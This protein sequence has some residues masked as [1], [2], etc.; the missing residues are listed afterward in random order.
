MSAISKQDVQSRYTNLSQWLMWMPAIVRMLDRTTMPTSVKGELEV[1]IQIHG[2]NL[3]DMYRD[4]M[5][6]YYTSAMDEDQDLKYGDAFEVMMRVRGVPGEY[7]S[8]CAVQMLKVLN[9]YATKP[10]P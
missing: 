5:E 7:Q 8:D 4:D 6:E 3:L 9:N 1:A 2:D 10:A